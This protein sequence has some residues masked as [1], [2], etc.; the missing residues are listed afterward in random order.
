MLLT[1]ALVRYNS[2]FLLPIHP[3]GGHQMKNEM[4]LGLCQLYNCYRY[5]RQVFS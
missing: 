2:F 3:F 1:F 4:I 5:I